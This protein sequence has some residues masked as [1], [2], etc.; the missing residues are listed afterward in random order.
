M[1]KF[2]KLY[3]ALKFRLHGMGYFKAMQAL[4][5]GR[6]IHDSIRKD[7][8]TPE[9]QHQLEKDD[10][11]AYIR[12]TKDRAVLRSKDKFAI[13]VVGNHNRSLIVA[14]AHCTNYF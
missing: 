1:S 2:S 8:V 5:K 3:I 12:T 14:R 10:L 9:Y 6:E 11:F 13:D 7:G 4:E